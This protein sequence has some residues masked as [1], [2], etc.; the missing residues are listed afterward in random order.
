[1][2]ETLDLILILL[3]H[4]FL[5]ELMISHVVNSLFLFYIRKPRVNQFVPY[6]VST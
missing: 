5:M 4:I 3:K 1:M 2:D 6:L